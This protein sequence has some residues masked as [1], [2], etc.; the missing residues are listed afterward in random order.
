MK[1]AILSVADVAGS[2]TATLMERGHE[3]TIGPFGHAPI[4]VTGMI[5][6]GIEGVLILTDDDETLEEIAA[7]FT[8]AT[9][10]P[11][12]RNMTEIPR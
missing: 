2:Y 6:D 1:I 10:R 12:W 8:R 9:G 11:V 7:R 5:E 3:I 4:A